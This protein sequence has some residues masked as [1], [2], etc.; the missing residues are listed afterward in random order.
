[1]VAKNAVGDLPTL[2]LN[3]AQEGVLS[4]ISA[5]FGALARNGHSIAASG[6]DR[7]L[8]ELLAG[9]VAQIGFEGIHPVNPAW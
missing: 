1:M 2:T 7:R 3:L 4:N 9:F 8:K 6:Y 5:S